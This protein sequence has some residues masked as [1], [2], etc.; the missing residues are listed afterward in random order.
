MAVWSPTSSNPHHHES[1]CNWAKRSS[2]NAV[3]LECQ[4]HTSTGV[5]TGAKSAPS[6]DAL[7]PPSTDWVSSPFATPSAPTLEL[8]LVRPSTSRVESWPSPIASSQSSRV[9]ATRLAQSLLSP[10]PTVNVSAKPML[11]VHYAIVASQAHS[12]STPPIHRAAFDAS[13]WASSRAASPLSGGGHRLARHGNRDSPPATP[14]LWTSARLDLYSTLPS[15]GTL[16][17]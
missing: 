12:S 4:L 17:E 2:S 9:A 6:L 11:R 7:K 10:G 8:T 3:P 16:R 15:T 1:K 14:S 5:S 13:A